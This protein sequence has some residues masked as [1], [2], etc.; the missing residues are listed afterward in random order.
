VWAVD[1]LLARLEQGDTRVIPLLERLGGDRIQMALDDH[2][3][4][5]RIP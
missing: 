5:R 2:R 3:A 1:L 4:G